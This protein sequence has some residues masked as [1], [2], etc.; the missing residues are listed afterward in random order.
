M[1]L[2]S[3]ST[4]F[5]FLR[6]FHGEEQEVDREPARAVIVPEHA[7]LRGLWEVCAGL[8]RVMQQHRPTKEVTLGVDA[9]LIETHKAQALPCYKGYPAYQ[10]LNCYVAQWDMVAYSQFR[11]G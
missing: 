3:P 1:P 10:P 4:V 7:R 6:S 8:L 9:T 5:R 11:D 2:P